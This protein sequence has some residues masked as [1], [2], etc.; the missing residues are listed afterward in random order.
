MISFFL[1]VQSFSCFEVIEQLSLKMEPTLGEFDLYL[2]KFIDDNENL[3]LLLDYDGTLAPI[4]PHPNLTQM[5]EATKG[6]LNRIAA[7]PK[8]F[9]AAISV[10]SYLFISRART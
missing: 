1:L 10:N 3:V 6:A 5:S 4:A 9:T 7:N 2:E 8:V